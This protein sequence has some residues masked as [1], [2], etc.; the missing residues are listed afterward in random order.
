MTIARNDTVGER[1]DAIS[2]GVRRAAYHQM[3]VQMAYRCRQS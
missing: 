1:F 2:G 3:A